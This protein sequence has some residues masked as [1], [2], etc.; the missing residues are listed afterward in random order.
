MAQVEKLT[1]SIVTLTFE[2]PNG[3]TFEARSKRY[4]QGL[5]A[6]L[7][8]LDKAHG[9]DNMALL[10]QYSESIRRY[11]MLSQQAGHYA[12][13]D[14]DGAREKY[15]R[16]AEEAADHMNTLIDDEFA[17]D[18]ETEF[19][20]YVEA[21]AAHEWRC[22]V[23]LLQL[24]V[25]T[26]TIKAQEHREMIASEPDSEFWESQGVAELEAAVKRFRGLRKA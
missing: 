23:E 13:I 20:K 17:G 25:D 3:R 2:T 7:G 16:L 26:D 15:A 8:R 12:G 21:K 11:A 9:A 10:K 19:Q 18:G 6:E 24:I 22:L 14:S 4:T 5:S 1:P